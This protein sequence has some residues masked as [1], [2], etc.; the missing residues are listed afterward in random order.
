MFI[1]IR[2]VFKKVD[3]IIINCAVMKVTIVHSLQDIKRCIILK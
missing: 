2:F 1:G 3:M